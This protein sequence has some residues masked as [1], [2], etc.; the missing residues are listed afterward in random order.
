MQSSRE[1]LNYIYPLAKNNREVIG[2]SQHTEGVINLRER[3]DIL[4]CEGLK[5]TIIYQSPMVSI[6][7]AE[8]EKRGCP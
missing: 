4:P 3:I 1:R 5:S 2:A 7:F 6:I 8:K